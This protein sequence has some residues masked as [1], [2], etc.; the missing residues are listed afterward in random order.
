MPLE[1]AK[2]QEQNRSK[3]CKEDEFHFPNKGYCASQSWLLLWILD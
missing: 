2:M 1:F 3:I